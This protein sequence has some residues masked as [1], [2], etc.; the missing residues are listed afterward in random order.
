M[1]ICVQVPFCHR[2]SCRAV[3]LFSIS[4]SYSVGEQMSLDLLHAV[5]THGHNNQDRG[6]AEVRRD[7]QLVADHFGDQAHKRKV[8]VGFPG[9]TDEDFAATC[10]RVARCGVFQ[11]PCVSLQCAAG[12]RPADM[13]GQLPKSV[14]AERGRELGRLDWNY[15]RRISSNCWDAP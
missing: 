8:T 11:N 7:R 9:E 2:V 5:D 4:P 1:F 15:G 14:K 6:S 3:A 10:T 12:R 13:P